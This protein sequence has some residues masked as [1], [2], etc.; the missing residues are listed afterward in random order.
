[1][2]VDADV[3]HH[4]GQVRRVDANARKQAVEFLPARELGSCA[5]RGRGTIS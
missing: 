5:R 2:P 1:M 4:P 3:G